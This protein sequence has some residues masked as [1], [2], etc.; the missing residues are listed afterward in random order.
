MCGRGAEIF[1]QEGRSR[2]HLNA[3]LSHL[4]FGANGRTRPHTVTKWV[5]YIWS[6][7]TLAPHD[8]DVEDDDD[9]GAMGGMGTIQRFNSVSKFNNHIEYMFLVSTHTRRNDVHETE[10]NGKAG[11][12]R[13]RGS[14]GFNGEW[15]RIQTIL[16]MEEWL[17]GDWDCQNEW[18]RWRHWHWVSLPEDLRALKRHHVLLLEHKCTLLPYTHSLTH[19]L[20]IRMINMYNIII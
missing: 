17:M 3:R 1:G 18:I 16:L 12:L 15:G 8:D 5:C 14:F 9:D 11:W 7:Y 6:L 20:C 13:L 19:T 2:D 4:T 10:S